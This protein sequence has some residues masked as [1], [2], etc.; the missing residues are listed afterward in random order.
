[1]RGQVNSKWLERGEIPENRLESGL[2]CR[3]ASL[4][5]GLTLKRQEPFS[6]SQLHHPALD[7]K[8]APSLPLSNAS[9]RA[10]G[11]QAETLDLGL[12][13]IERGQPALHVAKP[14]QIGVCWFLAQRPL[15]VLQL[16]I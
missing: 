14:S 16:P 8:S 15:S 10:A 3:P 9:G 5:P 11:R 2:E 7:A 6:Y 4:K 13:T 12:A 1:M